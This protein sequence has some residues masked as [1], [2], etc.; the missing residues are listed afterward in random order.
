MKELWRTHK[1]LVVGSAFSRDLEMWELGF[2]L[3]AVPQKP[4]L[5]QR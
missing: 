4:V 2:K 5:A 3:Y 1:D